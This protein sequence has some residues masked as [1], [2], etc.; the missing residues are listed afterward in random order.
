MDC[1]IDDQAISSE[2]KMEE[3]GYYTGLNG[4]GQTCVILAILRKQR[5]QFLMNMVYWERL[6]QEH[7]LCFCFD[8]DH[9]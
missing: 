5:C 7:D 3:S 4:L 2:S 8:V 6:R 1:E 9:F